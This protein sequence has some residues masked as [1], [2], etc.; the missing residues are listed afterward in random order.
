MGQAARDLLGE[1]AVDQSSGDTD[2]RGRY[3][4]LHVVA[5]VEIVRLSVERKHLELRLTGKD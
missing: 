1:L 2:E 4:D 5:D 3:G